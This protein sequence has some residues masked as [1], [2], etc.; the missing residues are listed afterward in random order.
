M[1]SI[2]NQ[3]DKVDKFYLIKRLQ[4]RCFQEKCPKFL[5][6]FFTEHLDRERDR[7]IDR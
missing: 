3:V 2:F 7:W 4:N 5:R 1:E 6:M